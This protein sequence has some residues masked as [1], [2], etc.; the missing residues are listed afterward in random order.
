M[1]KWLMNKSEEAPKPQE[2][3]KRHSF[4]STHAFDRDD[5]VTIS[6]NDI[7]Q[8][9]IDAA[10]REVVVLGAQDDSD[11]NSTLKGLF[12]NS[13]TMSDA[14]TMWYASQGFIGHHLCA[15]LA[16]H[17]LI[18]KAC[19]MPG[20]DAI[21]KG[22]NITSIDGDELE[23]DVVKLMHQYDRKMRLN[24]NLEQ[25]IRMGRIFGVRVALFKVESTDPD[26]YE[27][28]FNIDGVT[29]NS[30][31]GIVQVDPYWCAPMLDQASA[32]QPNTL[33]FYEPTYWII[34]GKKHHRSHLIIYR[35][36]EP[37]DLLKPQY[38]YGGV[39]VPQQ[40]MERVYASERVANEAP[41]LAQTKRTTVWMTDMEKF[42]SNGAD[43]IKNM[44]DWVSFRDNY[45]VKMGDKDGDEFNQF[46]TSLTDLDSVIMTQYQIVAA[47][48][49]VPATK[50][51]GTSPKGFNSSGEYEE[52]NYHEEL[53]SIQ[54]HDLTPLIER[55]HQLVMKSY[56]IPRTK[57][58]FI[59]TTV[60]WNPLDSQTA[61]ELAQTNLAKAQAGAQLVASG[62]ISSEDERKRVAMDKDSG[63]HDLGLEENAD[64]DPDL[65]QDVTD[66]MDDKWI[67]VHPHKGKGT[68][69]LLG[70]NG[71]V[72]AG[73][74]GKFNGLHIKEV[75]KQQSENVGHGSLITKAMNSA[76][77]DYKSEES[78]RVEKYNS[79]HKRI[80]ERE[81]EIPFIEPTT[82][83][84][85]NKADMFSSEASTG[86]TTH[87]F[88]PNGNYHDETHQ[89]SAE[90]YIN[91]LH[92][93]LVSKG[94]KHKELINGHAY[95]KNN[96]QVQVIHNFNDIDLHDEETPIEVKVTSHH[97]EN[98]KPIENNEPRNDAFLERMTKK[99]EERKAKK[100]L[101]PEKESIKRG[102]SQSSL[103]KYKNI[104]NEDL[105]LMIKE[106]EKQITRN[107]KTGEG[108]MSSGTR[109]TRKA[110]ANH[111]AWMLSNLNEEIKDVIKQ[112]KVQSLS[113]T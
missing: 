51:L 77:K 67:T 15:M 31:K 71:E 8:Q 27:K 19:T 9:N 79:T 7:I 47:A 68:P 82:T 97:K 3:K 44:N 99:A 36:A 74:G 54:H 37:A 66:A 96:H 76:K 53:E 84:K 107:L 112:R 11:G 59:E 2:L 45:G 40:I 102:E 92:H 38:L 6:V 95:E 21:R 105:E 85:T 49:G 81:V 55:H 16:Q 65:D 32:S 23:E 42:A 50:L 48:S 10:P 100:A 1:F 41:Q 35:H 106:N 103:E 56:V 13:V 24:W 88:K 25:F 61:T 90:H 14:L 18:N 89:K 73:M 12:N 72:K 17:W 93:E 30:Y 69:V 33:H 62:A 22:F 46:D 108:E 94:Y 80:G 20:R 52:A 29:S 26:Y 91:N 43:S 110:V 101:E 63:Y 58:A 64:T 60:M 83:H 39:P 104:T 4:F 87:E 111:S 86:E 70:E 78:E 109:S 34:N 5:M 28:P 75:E 113:N 98:D 57:T